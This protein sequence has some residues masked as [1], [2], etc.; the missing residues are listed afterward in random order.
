[1]G[2]KER[3]L[4]GYEDERKRREKEL[5]ERHQIVQLR[6][7]LLD[8]M[9]QRDKMR[10][11]LMPNDGDVS[12]QSTQ[13]NIAFQ[14]QLTTDKIEAR[15]KV[16]IF[17]NAFRKIKEATGVS[18]VNEVIQKITSQESSQENLIVLTKENQGKI[19]ELN[20]LRRAVKGKVEE[21]KYSGVSGGHRRK[22]VDDHEDQLANSSARM[23]RS[24]LKFERLTKV[25]ISMKGEC[26]F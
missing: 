11:Q 24:R 16:D 7:Q 17:E 1:M 20:E 14:K 12:E 21:V 19:E 5:R 10:S 4:A 23:E 26:C 8:R 25:I 15:N 13:H 3:V 6:K 2:E 18:D 22:L 9:H